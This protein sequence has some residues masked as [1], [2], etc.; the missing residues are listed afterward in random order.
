R[1]YLEVLTGVFGGGPVGVEALAATLSLAAD[2]LS[3]EVE[4]FLLRAEFVIR[5][6]RGRM[7]TAK[8]YQHLGKAMPEDKSSGQATLFT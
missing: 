7:A 1:R 6:P 8:A 4:P 5:S 2:T 3:D